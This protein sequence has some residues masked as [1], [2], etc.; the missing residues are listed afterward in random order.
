MRS[1]AW[2]AKAA[3]FFIVLDGAGGRT[4]VVGGLVRDTL[5]G[6][7]RTMTDIDMATELLPQE[8]MVRGERAGFAVHPTGID[9]GTVTLVAGGVVAEVTTLRKDIETFGRHAR[10]DFGTDWTADAA[11]RDFTMNA[12]YAGPDGEL[13]DP[14]E[15]LGDCLARRVRFIGDADERIAEDRL[16]VYRYFRFCA[17]HGEEQFDDTALEACSRAARSLHQLSAE[18]IGAEMLKLLNAPRCTATLEKM[19]ALAVLD[20]DVL[21]VAALPVLAR[22][23]AYPLEPAAVVRMAVMAVRGGSAGLLQKRWRLSNALRRG[24]E[25]LSAGAELAGEKRFTALAY[26]FPEIKLEAVAVAGAVEDWPKPRM[27]AVQAEL[28][29]YDPGEFP[30][31]G[32]DLLAAGV[33]KGEMLGQELRRL[34]HEWI[35]SEFA[36]SRQ[37]LLDRIRL[38]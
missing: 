24:I 20:E 18:R 29:G 10:V 37:A 11:R 3:P 9:H 16:R 35:E 27:E 28:L 32:R 30:L 19:A 23:E 33:P 2:L 36:L 22:L 5:L 8:V 26:R 31:N 38:P 21:P 1:A 25:S 13:Y 17:T 4:R 12:L 7:E 34:E 6:I 15:G 14:V